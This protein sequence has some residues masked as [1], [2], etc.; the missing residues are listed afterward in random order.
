VSSSSIHAPARL[1]ALTAVAVSTVLLTLLASTTPAAAKS[2]PSVA[3]AALPPGRINHILVVELE[4]EGYAT[5]FGPGSPATYLNGSLRPKGELLQ[6]YYAIGH[7]SLDN[8]IA[9]VSGQAPT[10]DTQAD[11]SGNGF[12]FADVTP[13]TPDANPVLN[14]G[15]VDGLGCVYPAAVPTIASQLDSR[16]PPSKATHVAAWRAYEQDMGNTPS[17]D[18]GT[19][20]RGGGTDCGHPA[21]GTTDTAEVAT[22]VDQYTSRHNPFVWFHSVIDHSVECNA[23]VV[24][25]GQLDKSGTPVPTG[26]LAQDLRSE[27]TTPRFGFV[28]PNL[29]NDGH[30]GTCAG[31]NSTGGHVGGL[32]GADEF[33]RAWMPLILASPAYKHGDMLVVVAFD[34]ADLD[35]PTAGAA[36]CSEASGPNTHAPGS[37]GASTDSTAP[38]GGQVGAVL[39]NAKYITPGSTDTIGSYNHY[40]ALRSYEDLLGLTTGGVDG[41]GHLG[42]A[43]AIGLLPFGPDVFPAKLSGAGKT[44]E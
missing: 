33:L 9:Q 34:E 6:N 36:C 44:K 13:G 5:T 41:E 24:P 2:S 22:P 17:R 18:G 10:T 37:P 35:G 20:D 3:R 32:T 15:Q 30:D 31:P 4:N 7:A 42:F 21:I 40:S 39:L 26:H 25:L 11:C 16:N 1:R 27:S 12:A 14:P 23:N 38:G 8:Y 19:A 43:A 28:T 29:C